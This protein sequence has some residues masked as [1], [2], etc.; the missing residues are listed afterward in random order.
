MIS[1]LPSSSTTDQ[2]LPVR[3]QRIRV[4]IADETPLSCQLLKDALARS[5][6]RFDIVACVCD[7]AEFIRLL[8]AHQTDVA[9]VSESLRDGSFEGFDLL[10]ELRVSF[11]A[12][13]VIMLLKLASRDLV[14]DAF[15]A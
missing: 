5:H 1:S 7:R 13:R 9:L 4:L 12:T 8:K 10:N 6:S 15:R 2:P 11:P 3:A 14:I